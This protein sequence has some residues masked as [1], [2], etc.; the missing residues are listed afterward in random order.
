M[1]E[2]FENICMLQTLI[3]P[4]AS[5]LQVF[6]NFSSHCNIENVRKPLTS[7]LFDDQFSHRIKRR[8]EEILYKNYDFYT[9]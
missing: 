8:V 5:G 4:P 6:L 7:V 2:E 1:K 9:E 3:I